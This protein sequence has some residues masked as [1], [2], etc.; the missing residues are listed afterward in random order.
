MKVSNYTGILS[1]QLTRYVHD[2]TPWMNSISVVPS[3]RNISS[4]PLDFTPTE[5][6]YTIQP[7]PACLFKAP[8]PHLGECK[9]SEMR[10]SQV[11]LNQFMPG[12]SRLVP[13]RCD[14]PSDGI[15]V[16]DDGKATHRHLMTGE[17]KIQAHIQ[18]EDICLEKWVTS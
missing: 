4:L 2:I 1:D 17:Y 10:G 16:E 8:H 3:D 18:Y 7:F 11:T 5:L 13:F 15:H 14:P 6:S 9:Q 12:P